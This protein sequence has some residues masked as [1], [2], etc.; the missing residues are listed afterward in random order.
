MCLILNAIPTS[1]YSMQG[2]RGLDG[3]VGETGIMGI[4]VKCS[5][6]VLIELSYC[7]IYLTGISLITYS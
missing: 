6:M 7:V 4:K 1:I 2:E 3:P 5:A